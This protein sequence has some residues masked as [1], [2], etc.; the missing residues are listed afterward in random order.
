M[1]SPAPPAAELVT[2]GWAA[3]AELV[4]TGWAAAELVT[5]SWAEGQPA[6][7]G[8]SNILQ[9]RFLSII[10]YNCHHRINAPDLHNRLYQYQFCFG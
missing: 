7:L 6:P 4:T 8:N 3:A 9:C 10:N 1:Q 2:T 5:I